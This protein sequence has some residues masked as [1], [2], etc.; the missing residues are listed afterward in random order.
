MKK[1]FNVFKKLPSFMIT[2]GIFL[3]VIFFINIHSF[4]YTPPY[5]ARDINSYYQYTE[6]NDVQYFKITTTEPIKDAYVYA[7][8]I[9]DH[10]DTV[11][12]MLASSK[13]INHNST[14]YKIFEYTYYVLG[15]Y[16]IDRVS[17]YKSGG[18]QINLTEYTD[19]LELNRIAREKECKTEAQNSRTSGILLIL[20]S[21]V[22]ICS[23]ITIVIIKTLKKKKENSTNIIKDKQVE[24]AKST[25]EK[26][27]N[28][29]DCPYCGTDNPLTATKCEGCGASLKKK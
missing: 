10:Y 3:L 26:E 5:Q 4:F 18:T 25:I 11:D 20:F 17:V 16:S 29:K 7:Y 1:I 28:T 9:Y 12:L 8:D 22:L 24:I 14:G 19:N 23:G 6:L 2:I 21:V 13:L 15:D 27:D